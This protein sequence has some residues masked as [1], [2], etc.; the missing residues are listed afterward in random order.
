MRP[1]RPEL[2]LG[3]LVPFS[4]PAFFVTMRLFGMGKAIVQLVDLL[5]QAVAFELDLLLATGQ[6]RAELFGCGHIGLPHLAQSLEFAELGGKLAVA[7]TELLGE[8]V[9]SQGRSL[10]RLGVPGNPFIELGA[11]LPG[12]WLDPEHRG[13]ARQAG[14]ALLER[15]GTGPRAERSAS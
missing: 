14:R 4:E 7:L 6:D 9:A 8:I 3:R 5:P 2:L 15:R 1:G 10:Q 12:C 13:A 11:E